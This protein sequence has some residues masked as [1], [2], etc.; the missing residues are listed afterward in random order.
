MNAEKIP[1][2][3]LNN[4]LCIVRQKVRKNQW[5]VHNVCQSQKKPHPTK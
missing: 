3:K 4:V 2:F 5:N 1:I